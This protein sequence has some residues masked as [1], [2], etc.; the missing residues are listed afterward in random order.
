KGSL[1]DADK[2]RFDFSHNKAMHEDE[3][4]RVEQLVDERIKQR[5]PVYAE[6]APQ[7]QAL[8]IH[9]L[10]AVFGEKYPPMVRVV[11]IGV[12]AGELLKDP[13]NAKWQQYSIE[14]C[15]GTHLKNTASIEGFVIT[16]EESV[17][18]GIR[19]VVAL[20]GV[21]ASAA[22]SSAAELEQAINHARATP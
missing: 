19:R 13:T 12:P 5:L 17:S 14:F 6:V 1:V 16:S 18:K 11:S 15:G 2:L 21:A 7:E 20:T 4:A 22:M 8:K 3:I 9:G 10:R